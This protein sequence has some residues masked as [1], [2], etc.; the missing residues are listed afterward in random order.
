M[1]P[2]LFL[3]ALLVWVMP[4]TLLSEKRGKPFVGIAAYGLLSN[5]FPKRDAEKLMRTL[6]RSPRPALSIVWGSFGKNT[7]YLIRYLEEF[8]QIDHALII[9]LSNEV[10]KR[11]NTCT[12]LDAFDIR[13][14]LDEIH[15]VVGPYQHN[16]SLTLYITTG[17]E[18]QFGNAEHDER[19]YEIAQVFPFAYPVINAIDGTG[20]IR[21]LLHEF[22]NEDEAY[23]RRLAFCNDGVPFDYAVG[24]NLRRSSRGFMQAARPFLQR[25]L[26]R[27]PDYILLWS[28]DL[29]GL[30]LLP[31]G[32][33]DYS[34]RPHRRA[35]NIP[36]NVFDVFGKLMSEVDYEHAR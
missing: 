5:K 29:Q 30:K 23:G 19:I 20:N 22:H 12:R 26:K 2:L 31:N 28:G 15:A 10:C 32:R 36:D 6:K 7:T 14:R 1:W 25:T 3:L 18:A 33:A 35:F 16:S 13:E 8:K 24:S 17:L 11:H 9:H 27:K 4:S 34:I 21:G